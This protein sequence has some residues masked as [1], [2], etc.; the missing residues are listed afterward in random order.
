[1]RYFAICFSIFLATSAMAAG[2]DCSRAA[3][4]RPRPELPAGQPDASNP[5]QH[6]VVIMQENHSFDNY[7][8]SL[9]KPEFYGA[10]VDGIRPGLS[11][12]D[13]HGNPVPV[14]KEKNLCVADPNHGW[15]AVHSDWNQGEIDGFVKT[16]DQSGQGARV[17]GY[18]DETDL[19]YYYALANTF[20][21]GDRYFS[22]VLSQTFPNRFYLYAGTSFGQVQNIMPEPKVGYAQ[23]SIFAL[24][25]ENGVSW[26]YYSD[27][28][29]YLRL[30]QPVFLRDLAKTGR[31]ADYEA[32][33][34]KGTLP[35]VVFLDPAAE[36]EDEHPNAD[37]QLGQSWVARQVNSLLSSSAWKDS[38][39][40]LTY[41]ENGGFFDHVAPPAACKPDDVAP[42]LTQ[43]FVPGDFAN[44][45][46]RVPFVA[47][48]PY[49]KHHFVSHSVF[50][51]SSILKFIEAK[52]NLPAL[53]ARDAN[54]D[55]FS[56]VFDFAHPDF[57]V[58]SL[59]AATI[60]PA[61]ACNLNPPSD[62][63]R[64]DVEVQF[65]KSGLC[66]GV[67]AG[68]AVMSLACD[69]SPSQKFA[70]QGDAFH[71]WQI[72][73]RASGLCLEAD[74]ASKVVSARA[75]ALE[76]NQG[77]EYG[78]SDDRKTWE[79]A[80]LLGNSCFLPGAV[81][82]P[83]KVGDCADDGSVELLLKSSSRAEE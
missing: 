83:L 65:Q 5:I 14:F 1:M 82:E 42:L 71:T 69:G 11:N 53:S 55:G 33:L 48:S 17:M 46:F 70:F 78:Q 15:N 12:P 35:Q 21:I 40:F 3:G 54:A 36:G 31:I 61:R 47:I 64:S 30:F 20:A 75:C 22:S 81:N 38:V 43:G 63:P 13:S 26:K 41:D 58:P 4:T 74:P 10:E 24:L 7:F 27:G 34:A 76:E 60:D 80:G 39:V 25:D 62:L 72:R 79:L 66:L 51:H 56:D 77:F 49:A 6:I 23:K 2:P 9:A 18:Y 59:P 50:D 45:G 37:V 16:N 44:Y 52:F 8:G 28:T 67:S 19:P 32:D 68:G 73:N 57:T 29:A